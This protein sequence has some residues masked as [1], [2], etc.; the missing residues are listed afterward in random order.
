[1]RWPWQHREPDPI[2]VEIKQ[3]TAKSEKVLRRAFDALRARTTKGIDS[4]EQ[5]IVD[6]YARADEERR[7]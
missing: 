5:K 3:Q 7:K 1:M 2:E 4:A 6:D